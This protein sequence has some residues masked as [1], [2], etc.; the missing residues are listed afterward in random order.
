MIFKQI[1]RASAAI[2]RVQA[3]LLAGTWKWLVCVSK[4]FPGEGFF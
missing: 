3:V 4:T 2:G 1:S